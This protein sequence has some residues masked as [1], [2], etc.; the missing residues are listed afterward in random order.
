MSHVN[1]NWRN[2]SSLSIKYL[3]RWENRIYWVWGMTKFAFI[4]VFRLESRQCPQRVKYFAH[5]MVF[6][7]KQ[8]LVTPLLSSSWFTE[9]NAHEC[10]L[11]GMI[12]LLQFQSILAILL[13]RG[14]GLSDP[15][16]SKTFLVIR[17]LWYTDKK[18]QFDLYHIGMC[19]IR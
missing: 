11:G 10:R 16:V 19:K 2:N 14:K 13:H 17:L 1:S 3:C 15:N 12:R 8:N 7:P 18:S 9:T 6:L 4:E 5:S